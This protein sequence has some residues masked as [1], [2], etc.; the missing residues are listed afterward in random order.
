M[1]YQTACKI[2]LHDR[3]NA[4]AFDLRLEA[5][6]LCAATQA[7]QFVMVRCGAEH[8]LR[9]PISICDAH[10]GILRLVYEVRG[11]GTEWLS[12]RTEGE[13][14]DILGPL[15]SGFKAEGQRVLFIGGGIG[16]PPLFSAA[17]TASA[18]DA[19]LGF[20]SPA[21]AILTEDMK[22]LPNC[23]RIEVRYDSGASKRGTAL[24]AAKCLL[25]NGQTY[26]LICA[27][28]PRGLLE[29]ASQLA[30]ERDI[31]CRISM[32]ER[33][34]CGIGACL[35][36]AV[37]LRGANE[38]YGHVCKDGPVFWAQEVVFDD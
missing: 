1:P 15:G 33:M 18:F 31:P 27:C 11:A 10:N 26:D 29:A 4:F 7:G 34:G 21:R 3:I 22:Q 28:G 30:Q 37:K 6:E 35:V 16:V 14:L 2:L 38:H 25:D 19:A 20:A 13:T 17:R 9:R 5:P 23:G 36:C 12:K 24:D 8:L 32:E